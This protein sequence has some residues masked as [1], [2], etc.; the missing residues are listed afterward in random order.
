MGSQPP[1]V[2]WSV[3]RDAGGVCKTVESISPIV[4][5]NTTEGTGVV[6]DL[7]G[8]EGAKVVISIGTALDTL[9]SDNYI[10]PSLTDCATSDGTFAA[11]DSTQYRFAAG[12]FGAASD[13]DTDGRTIEV[14]LQPG[15]SKVE[16]FIKPLLTFTGTHTNGTPIAAYVEKTHPRV[17]P[18]T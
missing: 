4:G 9:D 13:T 10:T 6:V 5:N 8:Y 12:D 3:H 17:A 7:K 1:A 2:G 14:V 15:T 16:R 11:L 18:L